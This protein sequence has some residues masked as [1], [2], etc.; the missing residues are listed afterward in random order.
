M[1]VIAGYDGRGWSWPS[2]L[3]AQT[4]S[5]SNTISARPRDTPF[6]PVSI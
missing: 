5:A 6:L 2:N 3:F 4:E 1:A